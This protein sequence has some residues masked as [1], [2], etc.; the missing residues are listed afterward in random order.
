MRETGRG[1]PEE[2][3]KKTTKAEVDQ[4]SER[5]KKLREEQLKGLTEAERQNLLVREEQAKAERERQYQEYQQKQKEGFANYEKEKYEL[6][7]RAKHAKTSQELFQLFLDTKSWTQQLNLVIWCKESTNEKKLDFLKAIRNNL[8][9]VIEN[10]E[11]MEDF[12]EQKDYYINEGNNNDIITESFSSIQNNSDWLIDYKEYLIRALSE[13]LGNYDAPEFREDAENELLEL[14]QISKS[15]LKKYFQ[16]LEEKHPGFSDYEPSEDEPKPFIASSTDLQFAES[17][18]FG[19]A[20]GYY[21]STHAR[22]I[23]ALRQAGSRKALEPLYELSAENPGLFTGKLA[24]A[25]SRIAPEEAAHHYIDLLKSKDNLVRKEAAAILF[26][27]EFGRIGISEDGVDYLGRQYDLGQHNNSDYFAQ[28]LTADGEIGVFNEKRE[29]FKHFNLGD[30]SDGQKRIKAA[31]LDFTYETLF[32][33]KKDETPEERKRRE[34]VLEEFQKKYFSFY[35]SGFFQNTRIHFNNLSF[36]EQG[37]FLHFVEKNADENNEKQKE[38]KKDALD[39]VRRYGEEGFRTFLSLEHGDEMGERILEIGKNLPEQAAS[40]IFTKYGQII[41]SSRQIEEYAKANFGLTKGLPSEAVSQITENLL[42][43]GKDTLIN[44]SEKSKSL[45]GKEY[46][47]TLKEISE[48]LAHVRAEVI[49]FANTF[50]EAAKQP[51]FSAQEFVEKAIDIKDSSELS[52]EEKR[53]MTEIFISNRPE[54]SAELLDSDLQEFKHYLDNKGRQFRLLKQNGEVISFL[55]IDKLSEKRLYAGSFNLSPDARG[56][57]I[58]LAMAKMVI[59]ELGSRYEIEADCYSRNKSL[60][61]FYKR[62]LGF[63][64]IGKTDEGDSEKELVK[65][66]RPKSVKSEYLQG[67]AA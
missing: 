65:L 67:K 1:I 20:E 45:V 44:F 24:D 66:V 36:R 4:L 13:A 39:F 64:E 57:S 26:R 16:E 21:V 37:W 54:F 60:L 15:E 49:L 18:T 28:R 11:K 19:F 56:T 63:K 47:E 3:I 5:G 48:E 61:L 50:R 62:M 51:D 30:L 35:N 25:L 29:L 2:E 12:Y 23:E 40:A 14:L 52:Q 33:A 38:K 59:E 41:D 10:N 53:Q 22:I 8:D 34:K 55:R 42:R 27:L 17:E 6:L 31:V 32:S 58:A 43:K 9:P 7:K 46:R